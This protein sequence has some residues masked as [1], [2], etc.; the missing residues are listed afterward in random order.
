MALIRGGVRSSSILSTAS[1]RRRSVAVAS[2][3]TPPFAWPIEFTAR[4]TSA[5]FTVWWPKAPEGRLAGAQP[6]WFGVVST[7]ATTCYDCPRIVGIATFGCCLQDM[8]VWVALRRQARPRQ[9]TRRSSACT[10]PLC[11]LVRFDCALPCLQLVVLKAQHYGVLIIT[12]ARSCC[13]S[14]ELV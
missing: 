3:T 4:F 6:W 12:R 9:A 10:N 8:S 13:L 2:L 14:C 1:G 5:K 7:F 11:N